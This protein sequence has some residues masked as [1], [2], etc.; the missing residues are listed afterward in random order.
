MKKKI[1]DGIKGQ[2][3][4]QGIKLNKYRRLILAGASALLLIIV[5]SAAVQGGFSGSL[6][7]AVRGNDPILKVLID[8]EKRA[9]EQYISTELTDDKSLYNLQRTGDVKIFL[10]EVSEK[11]GSDITDFESPEAAEGLKLPVLFQE[12]NS[13]GRPLF[14]GFGA[15]AVADNATVEVKGTAKT[16]RKY[17]NFKLRLKDSAGRYNGQ[18]ILNLN[19]AYGNPCR[20]EEKFAF[21][22]FA[23]PEEMMSLR[24]EFV[25]LY[26]KNAASPDPEYESYGLYILT[27]QPDENYF[28]N[29]SLDAEGNLYKARNFDFTI[30]EALTDVDDEGYSKNSFEEL[31]DIKQ[32]QSHTALLSMTADVNNMEKDIDSVVAEHF[33]RDN[34]LTYLGMNVLLGNEEEASSGYLLYKPAAS[35]VWYILPE[36]M[37]ETMKAAAD[38]EHYQV[39]NSG[40]SQFCGNLLYERFLQKPA[41]RE[42]LTDRINELTERIGPDRV[43]ELTDGYI[44]VLADFLTVNPD[45][46]ML[47]A[48]PDDIIRTVQ[49]YYSVMLENRK[50]FLENI[51]RPEPVILLRAVSDEKNIQLRWQKP[52]AI[53]GEPPTYKVQVAADPDFKDILFEA[54]G[55]ET[56]S[57]TVPKSISGQLRAYFRVE[58]LSANSETAG[59]ANIFTDKD[60]RVFYGAAEITLA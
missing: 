22:L 8:R 19:K 49:N 57:C 15:S 50:N 36:D 16:N 1:T 12:G 40:V 24:T 59:S 46:G 20:I 55:L 38:P 29:R 3:S 13:A 54:A 18:S 51:D 30:S 11:N 34:L 41:N 26:V 2:E 43:R 7:N 14:G 27:E 31:L 58:A 35:A 47:K 45:K 17:H 28:L 21:D 53:L 44:P 6:R 52:R 32:G 60:G 10:L 42:A 5:A 56:E 33:N 23:L 9:D 48:S 37:G 39:M 4:E 25:L